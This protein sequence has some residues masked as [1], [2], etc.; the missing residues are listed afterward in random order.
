MP[1]LRFWVVTRDGKG[2]WMKVYDPK[3]E[4][5]EG[6]RFEFEVRAEEYKK[7]MQAE[8]RAARERMRGSQGGLL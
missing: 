8:D 4:V 3:G 6:T 1:G 7:K 5:K 2:R